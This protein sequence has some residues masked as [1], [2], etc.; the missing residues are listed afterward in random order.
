MSA[1]RPRI[2]LNQPQGGLGNPF[3][4]L[5]SGGLPDGPAP[6][7]AA[8]AKPAKLGR[9]VLRKEKSGRGGKTVIVVD[10]FATHL[11]LTFLETLARKLR[12]SCGC[13]GALKGRLIEL[14]GDQPARIREVLVAEG[15]QVAGVS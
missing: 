14:Q 7:P 8:A 12:N 11:P 4:G 9:V 13:G 15:F 5:E 6:A 2:P 1:K 3:A 10:D